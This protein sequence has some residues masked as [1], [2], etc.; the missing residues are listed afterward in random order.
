MHNKILSK[1]E[2]EKLEES[3]SKLEPRF[4]F[5]RKVTSV[6][7]ESVRLRYEF[8]GTDEEYQLYLKEF[9]ERFKKALDE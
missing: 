4:K 6:M 7:M 5:S 1:E 2:F 3:W 8:N 9:D